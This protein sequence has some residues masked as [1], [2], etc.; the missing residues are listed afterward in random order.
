MSFAQ[1]KRERVAPVLPLASMVDILFLLLIFFLTSA[2][3]R[4]QEAQI[5]VSLPQTRQGA[6]AAS[7]TQIVITIQEDG[8]IYIGPTRHTLDTLRSTLA[9]LARLSPDETV[10]IRG[11]QNSRFGLIVEIIDT[12]YSVNLRNVTVATTRPASEL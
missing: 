4:E 2:I 11:D 7:P 9:D 3:F 8:Q 6:A 10:V 1:Q 12:A 5:D